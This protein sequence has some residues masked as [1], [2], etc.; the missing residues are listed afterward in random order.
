MRDDI[1]IKCSFNILNS[2]IE[3]I[4]TSHY[5]YAKSNQYSHSSHQIDRTK[6]PTRILYNDRNVANLLLNHTGRTTNF[7]GNS[8][9]E[10][11]THENT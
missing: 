3:N 4:V 11:T 10:Q 9:V 1:D 2:Q 5:T 6:D 8:I 7:L